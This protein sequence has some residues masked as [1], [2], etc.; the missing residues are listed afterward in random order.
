MRFPGFVAEAS[1]SR[2][3]SHSNFGAGQ[4]ITEAGQV[5]LQAKRL[6]GFGFRDGKICVGIE[7]DDVGQSYEVCEDLWAD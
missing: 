2:G 4:V 7:D 6:V 1:I 5:Q 3:C